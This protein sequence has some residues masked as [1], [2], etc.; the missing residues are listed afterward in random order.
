[1]GFPTPKICL[2][3]RWASIGSSHETY[4]T[5]LSIGWNPHFG[6]EHK[7]CEPWILHTFESAF[8]GQ[9]VWEGGEERWFVF[10]QFI[11]CQ[12]PC[13]MPYAPCYMFHAA[14][15]RLIVCGYVRPEA[16]F[17]SLKVS[18]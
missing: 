12:A 9:E 16:K 3:A 10:S 8:Y 17:T 6:N 4:K 7:T 11:C 15:I 1:M 5:A 2:T 13:S 14:Q 18:W